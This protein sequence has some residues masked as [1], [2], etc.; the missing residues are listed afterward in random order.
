MLS[1][2]LWRHC[3]KLDKDVDCLMYQKHV[4]IPNDDIDTNLMAYAIMVV[5]DTWIPLTVK[6]L[7]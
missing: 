5:T 4:D 2:S 3:N 1:R 7:I 6:P